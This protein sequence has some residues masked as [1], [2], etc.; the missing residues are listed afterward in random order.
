MFLPKPKHDFFARRVN[1]SKTSNSVGLR[2]SKCK[3]CQKLIQNKLIPKC[4][5]VKN[6]LSVSLT[7]LPNSF[8]QKQFRSRWR[9]W[10]DDKISKI[11]CV[12]S[13]PLTVLSSKCC[14]N[15]QKTTF[16]KLCSRPT[17]RLGRWNFPCLGRSQTCSR[18]QPCSTPRCRRHPRFRWMPVREFHSRRKNIF[19]I[20]KFV[21]IQYFCLIWDEISIGNPN[22]EILNPKP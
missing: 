15:V 14:K 13:R 5:V 19:L 8:F 12:S 11:K 7:N 17:S 22:F 2:I 3:I 18:G 10:A 9:V 16:F 1:D 21:R 4:L 20:T 6:R